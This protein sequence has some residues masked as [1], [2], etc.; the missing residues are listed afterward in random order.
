MS[1]SEKYS[2][3]LERQYS[4]RF[5]SYCG[6]SETTSATR[7]VR[8]SYP[9]KTPENGTSHFSSGICRW[10]QIA[11]KTELFWEGASFRAYL[12]GSVV[13]GSKAVK[14]A[15]RQIG[16]LAEQKGC[17]LRV[18][19]DAGEMQQRAMLVVGFVR[20]QCAESENRKP[21]PASFRLPS[22]S[23]RIKTRRTARYS[24]LSFRM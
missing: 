7:R 24:V 15:N 4:F 18:V 5:L 21:V 13:I 23:G 11:G 1:S 19:A 6:S 22:K 10:R 2:P 8:V 16:L 20:L 14:V 17:D 12:K 3:F 9:R